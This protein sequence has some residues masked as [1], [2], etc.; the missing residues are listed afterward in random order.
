MTAPGQR[1]IAL[2]GSTGSIGVNCLDVV[3]RFPDRFN[4]IGLSAG[5]NIRLLAEQTAR[6]RP[7]VCVV[8]EEGDAGRLRD[9]L[10]PGCDPEILWGEPG[11][12][13]LAGSD[14]VD[15]VVSAV[16]GA[17]GLPPT[18]AA[19]RAGKRVA[20]ANKETMVMA[21]ELV[22]AEAKAAGAEIL[23]VDSEHSAIFQALSGQRLDDVRQL[24]LTASGG[25]FRDLAVRELETVTPDQAKAHPNWSMGDKI[26]VDSATLMNKGLEAIEARWLF[27]LDWDKISIQIHPQSIIHSMVEFVDGSVL[28]QLGRPDMR[29][30]IAYA[31]AY[32][33]RLPLGLPGLDLTRAGP[34]TFSEPDLTRF[35]CLALA[36]E[37]GRR[38]GGGPAVLNA[39]NEVA[40]Q[41][42]LA[43]RVGFTDIPVVVS[44]ALE[45]ADSG[46][47]DT[48]DR[49]RAFDREARIRAGEAV[50]NIEGDKP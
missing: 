7:R 34:L 1:Q 33:H 21:G 29:L 49:I 31:L 45:T 3:G 40:V 17:A 4:M 50:K 13:Q 22:M 19:V 15:T 14:E 48:L 39:A 32:P 10:G 38:G 9:L 30:P 6:F 18:W 27:G 24:I 46:P 47:A 36:L 23:P 41:A 44:K 37:A 43:G 28:A 12:V 42:F 8:L 16:V 35:P 20:L 5:R 25:P 26:S 11:L 2:L